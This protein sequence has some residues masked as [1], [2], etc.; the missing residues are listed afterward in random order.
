MLKHVP[1]EVLCVIRQAEIH[2]P[3]EA[4]WLMTLNSSLK[5]SNLCTIHVLA[6]AHSALLLVCALYSYHWMYCSCVYRASEPASRILTAISASC[7]CCA[8]GRTWARGLQSAPRVGI[9]TGQAAFAGP[10][11]RGAAAPP[12]MPQSC[13]NCSFQVLTS[14]LDFVHPTGRLSSVSYVAV[15]SNPGSGRNCTARSDHME[16]SCI[17]E[18]SPYS[19][20]EHRACISACGWFRRL[21]VCL[22]Q[23]SL[24]HV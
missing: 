14:I 17:P 13:N 9:T 12:A 10:P 23:I 24:P 18:R 11:S 20:R 3:L 15:T 2:Y 22:Q 21:L 4:C 1:S 16:A 6:L 19:F 7:T 8:A 5:Q